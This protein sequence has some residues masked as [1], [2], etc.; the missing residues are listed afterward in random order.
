MDENNTIENN[1]KKDTKIKADEAKK[2]SEDQVSLVEV[3]DNVENQQRLISLNGSVNSLLDSVNN[4][5]SFRS[6]EEYLNSQGSLSV[7]DQKSSIDF[8]TFMNNKENELNQKKKGRKHNKSVLNSKEDENINPFFLLNP[9][10]LESSSEESL[11]L[12]ENL[13]IDNNSYEKEVEEVMEKENVKK[14]K[15]KQEV[16]KKEGINRKEEKDNNKKPIEE[17]DISEITNTEVDLSSF[18]KLGNFIL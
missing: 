1:K 7:F 4:S 13:K 17:A 14:E 11:P 10:L 12:I 16:E 5:N 3:N 6:S 18:K 8:S 2:E 15:E 9:E